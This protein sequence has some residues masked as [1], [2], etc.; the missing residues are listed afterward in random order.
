MLMII[1]I[2]LNTNPRTPKAIPIGM[3]NSRAGPEIL[4]L[5]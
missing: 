3:Q 1:A 2:T 4:Q 5:I